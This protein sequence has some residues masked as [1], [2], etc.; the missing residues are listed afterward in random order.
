MGEVTAYEGYFRA[1]NR[2]VAYGFSIGV[3]ML[4]CA[5]PFIPGD[6][7]NASTYAFPVQFHLVSAA[8]PDAIAV[9]QDPEV[10]PIL[11]EAA[12]YLVAQGVRAITSN[13]GFMAAYQGA[14]ADGVD[15]PVF[16]STLM[17]V[18]LILCMLRA[19]QKL[20]VVVANRSLVTESLLDAAGIV[21]PLRDR[22]I[23]VGLEDQPAFSSTFL[24]ESG[25]LDVAAVQ[26][27]V[28]ESAIRVVSESPSVGAF[29]LECSD[30]PPYSAAV[31]RATG[32]PVFDWI[33]FINLVHHAVVQQPHGG[34]F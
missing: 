26:A 30:L 24:A 1:R 32:R 19:S 15:V 18:P 3:L 9:R 2:Q 23:F 4:D 25:E 33:G 28:V 27:E 8:T 7:G 29:L 5:I 22:C 31:Q 10:A 20:A 14:V 13:C 11:V 21:Q 16:L 17:Q 34:F 12:Q 6:V